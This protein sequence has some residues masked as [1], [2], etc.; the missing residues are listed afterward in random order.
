MILELGMFR[1]TIMGPERIKLNATSITEYDDL[2][3]QL[4][5]FIQASDGS[6]IGDPEKAVKVMIDLVKGEGV[7]EEKSLP[8]T[9]PFGSDSLAAM[10]GK[11]LANLAVCDEWEDLI[12]STDFE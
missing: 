12:R 6:Q 5:Q 3:E 7:G 4:V 9:L 1:T 11:A 10:R 8:G 2:R